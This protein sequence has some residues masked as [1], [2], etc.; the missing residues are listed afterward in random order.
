MSYYFEYLFLGFRIC[1]LS[2]TRYLTF[3]HL[4]WQDYILFILGGLA[5]GVINTLA[6]NGSAITLSL[7]IFTGMPADVANATNRIGA[8]VQ[9]VTAVLSLKRSKRTKMLLGQSVWFFIPAVLGSVLGAFIAVEIDPQLLRTIIGLIMLLLLITL[10][11]RPSK[12]QRSTDVGKN[13]RT[14]LNAFMIFV[15]AVYG[16]FLQMGIGIMLL[17]VLVLIAH[18][19]LRDAN[20]IKLILA[21]VF[22]LPAFIVFI[23]SGHIHWL[24]GVA[25]AVGQGIGAFI[26]ARY[27]LF[28]PKANVIIRWLLIVILSISS[29]LLLGLTELI[30]QIF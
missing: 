16:G 17:S 14:W 27:I 10:I 7:L 13:H 15:I 29:A 3:A 5:A 25:L 18:Y 6:G 30:R 11:T 19:S 26:G 1:L 9:T 28:L 4:E 8:F 23:A 24:P 2:N 21:A 20:I 12:W 22:V